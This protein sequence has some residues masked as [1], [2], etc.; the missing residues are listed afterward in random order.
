MSKTRPDYYEANLII[1]L[2]IVMK[3]I[4]FG[5]DSVPASHPAGRVRQSSTHLRLRIIFTR[6]W[7]IRYEI[8]A[9]PILWDFHWSD[10][11]TERDAPQSVKLQLISLF[12]INS[13]CITF[14]RN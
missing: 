3:R 6:T 7:L 12:M 13:T 1:A 5:S 4:S 8:R 9:Y 10:I 14:I 11:L 2:S